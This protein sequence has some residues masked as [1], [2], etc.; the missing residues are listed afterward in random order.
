MSHP[1]LYSSGTIPKTATFLLCLT[2]C[3]PAE[4][5]SGPDSQS[6]GNDK[7]A[8]AKPGKSADN[9]GKAQ[10]NYAPP[11]DQ[12]VIKEPSSPKAAAY[13]HYALGH[14]YEELAAANN[15]RSEY[16]NKAIENYQLTIKED[17]S[18]SFL[19]QDIAELYRTSGR[20]R[21][22]VEQAQAAIKKNPD[23][24]NSHRVLARI[25]TQQIGDAQANRVDE[26]MVKRAL[27]QYNIITEKDPKD[28]ESLVMMGRLQR[29]INNSVDAEATFKKALAVDPDNEDAITGLASLYSDRGDARSA[30]EL[31]EK[32][33][34]KNPSAKSYASLAASYESMREY[35]LAADAYSKALEIDPQHVELKEALAQD[36]AMAGRFDDALKTYADMVDDDPKSPKPYIGMSQIYREKKDFG[37]ARETLDRAK[38][39][40]PDNLEIRYSE[41]GLLE[42]EGK[43]PEAITALKSILDATSRRTY[44]APQR[45]F[46]SRLLEQLGLL[47]RNTRQ[48]DQAAATFH[49]IGTLNPDSA[50][51]AEAQVA[52]TYLAARNDAKA[53]QAA[54]AALRKYPNERTL[55]EVRAQILADQG[56]TDA[57]L[58]ELK[59]LLDGKNDREVYLAMADVHQKSK[60]FTQMAKDLD[61]AEKLS[62]TKEEK[63]AVL[64]M[65]GAMQEREK[66]YDQ[67]EKTFRQVL[68]MDAANASAM[69]YLGYMLADRGERL[70][71]AQNLITKAL[72]LEPNNYA[73]LDSLGWV[74][75]RMNKLDAAEQQLTRSIQLSASKDPTIHDHLGDVYF[76][77]GKIKDAVAQWQSSLKAFDSAPASEAEPDEVA[78]VRKKLDK[79]R[80]RLAKE[81]GPKASNN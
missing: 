8:Q 15:N 79:A 7:I 9:S 37:K 81:Q 35:S 17:P 65:R 67:A 74:Y 34:K 44:D 61:Q 60:N 58:A 12:P 4:A 56:K 63:S 29:V 39:I 50:P 23:D 57:A 22:A 24:L 64:F 26:G 20:I 5:L 45:T 80:V 33:A 13:Y 52:N 21:E 47:Y 14:L 27:E 73:F 76:K 59:N 2:V 28:T 49:D 38:A 31:L 69:N 42:N 78:K 55:H 25:Y 71:E 36:Q 10:K 75:Y 43:L 53:L 48:Y 46:R 1:Y 70:P 68:S 6:T 30:S 77:Q 16:V 32:M 11:S 72:E 66:Q 41:V 19:V 3:L 62:Q 40:D 51:R 18:T 54:D